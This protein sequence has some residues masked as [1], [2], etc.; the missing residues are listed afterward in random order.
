MEVCQTKLFL[1]PAWQGECKEVSQALT[2][3]TL[4]P[5]IFLSLHPS[6][7]VIKHL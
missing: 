4:F 7:I 2:L 5:T 6:D 3:F 1:T